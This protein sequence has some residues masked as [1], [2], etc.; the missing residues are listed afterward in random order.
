MKGEDIPNK[1]KILNDY[2]WN[3]AELDAKN[4]QMPDDKSCQ[5]FR[6]LDF[7]KPDDEFLEQLLDKAEPVPENLEDPDEK[8]LR[9]LA[10]KSSLTSA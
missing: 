2:I 1:T 3:F 5:Y 4:F 8:A 10:A 6:D 7:T 9:Y